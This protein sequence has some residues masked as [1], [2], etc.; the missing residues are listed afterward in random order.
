[1]ITP[2]ET[3]RARIMIRSPLLNPRLIRTSMSPPVAVSSTPVRARNINATFLALSLSSVM[4]VANTED[5]SGI[6]ALM[7]AELL[8]DV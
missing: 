5:V 7:V 4:N 8:A 2:A 3:M 1:M 6:S